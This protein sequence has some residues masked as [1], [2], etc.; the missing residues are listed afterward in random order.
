MIRK[1]ILTW[2]LA[3][4]A[5]AFF[6]STAV[7]DQE[8]DVTVTLENPIVETPVSNLAFGTIGVSPAGST[9]E[10]ITLNATTGSP[11]MSALNG[12]SFDV[13]SAT[14]GEIQIDSAATFTVNITYTGA[15]LV[16]TINSSNTLTLSNVSSNSTITGY[17]HD[18]G[19]GTSNIYIGGE[20]TIDPANYDNAL[21][22]TSISSGSPI[23]VT[24]T[25]N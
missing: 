20:L 25:Y 6:I 4:S 7:A 5:T 24:L 19:V 3:L 10:V 15:T 18:G 12:S 17:T 14:I 13:T 1:Q 9:S 16:S 23:T 2:F 11:V 8:I 21:Y 22:S